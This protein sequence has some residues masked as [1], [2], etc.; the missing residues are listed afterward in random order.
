MKAT[1]IILMV[2]AGLILTFSFYAY[3]V[4][5]GTPWGKEQQEGNMQ[6]Y[7][8]EKYQNEF[9]LTKMNYNFLSETYQGYAYLKDHSNLLFII[10]QDA[11]SPRGY[12]DNYPKVLWDSELATNLKTQI[13]ELFP[14]LDEGMFKA[15]QIKDKGEILG[16]NIP[17]YEEINVSILTTSIPIDIKINWSKINHNNELQKMKKLSQFL[18]EARFPVLFEVRYY[19]NEMDE[20]AKVFFITEEGDIIEK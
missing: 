1:K 6:N 20:Q 4:F 9:V 7:I 18:Q 10:E 11:D 12:S 19:E 14:D 2:F 13:K 16:P 5:Y 3:T 8:T 15:Q 17:T